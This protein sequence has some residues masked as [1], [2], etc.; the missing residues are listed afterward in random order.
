MIQSHGV[1]WAAYESWMRTLYAEAHGGDP[2]HAQ[3]KV[4]AAVAGHE[5][6]RLKQQKRAGRVPIYGV[7]DFARGL[8]LDPVAAMAEWTPMPLL[9][10]QS[11]QPAQREWVSQLSA[12]ELH[13]EVLKR[14]G[15][16][17]A[18]DSDFRADP[19]AW[20]CA[21]IDK[22][23]AE[24][25]LARS[26]ARKRAAQ[27]LDLPSSTLHAKER[28]GSWTLP[29]LDSLCRWT[30]GTFRMGLAVT[31]WFTWE[32]VGLDPSHRLQVL[33]RMPASELVSALRK[34]LPELRK[35]LESMNRAL[36]P[37]EQSKY[38]ESN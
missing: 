12:D 17:V 3:Y 37:K 9:K 34:G 22:P 32:E 27:V 10:E 33:A 30:G 31:G 38:P 6:T 24:P 21:L 4:L 35:H 7:R 8:G 15:H 5:P 13:A 2:R 29:E 16:D 18:A 23:A 14:L 36:E 26:Q 19:S 25:K 28:R 20:A 11:P 1:P